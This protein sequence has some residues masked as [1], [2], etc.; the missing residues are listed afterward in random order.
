MKEPK[1][2]KPRKPRKKKKSRGLEFGF[3]INFDDEVLPNPDGD[4]Y[5]IYGDEYTPLDDKQ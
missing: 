5:I 4:P 2:I 1:P 3:S